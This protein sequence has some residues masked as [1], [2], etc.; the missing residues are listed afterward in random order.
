MLLYFT[1][2]SPTSLLKPSQTTI[3]TITHK[4]THSNNTNASHKATTHNNN[5]QQTHPYQRSCHPRPEAALRRKRF[6][7]QLSSRVGTGLLW[8]QIQRECSSLAG[9]ILLA[10]RYARHSDSCSW[11]L[12]LMSEGPHGALIP[13]SPR[14]WQSP[15][16]YHTALCVPTAVDVPLLRRRGRA[17]IHGHSIIPFYITYHIS[18]LTS[19]IVC[20]P[21][22]INHTLPYTIC[23]I[24]MLCLTH[25]ISCTIY[26]LPL[27]QDL[28]CFACHM[29]GFKGHDAPHSIRH[30]LCVR[31]YYQ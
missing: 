5:K 27:S 17:C 7:S 12:F 9:L 13:P 16:V 10:P 15:G 21:S 18:Y 19:N 11:P 22:T 2:A 1:F 31:P 4:T 24:T 14:R 29:A 3:T 30:L 26:H 8:I 28:S 20:H 6:A 23:N 25:S